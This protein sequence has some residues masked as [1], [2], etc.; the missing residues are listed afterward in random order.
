MITATNAEVVRCWHHNFAHNGNMFPGPPCKDDKRPLPILFE[1]NPEA[2]VLFISHTDKN[3]VGLSI[4]MMH[5]YCHLTLIPGRVQDYNA[6]QP[7][8]AAPMSKEEYLKL[9]RIQ[10]L[11][12]ETVRRWMNDLGYNYSPWKKGYYNDKHEDPANIL[13][14]IDFIE[15]YKEYELRAH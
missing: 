9:H 1:C 7:A 12:F 2:M 10:N 13:Y 4:K 14:R 6:K 3:M 5:K 15:R 8:G 11:G